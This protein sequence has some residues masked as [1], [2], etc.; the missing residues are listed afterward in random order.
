MN[1]YSNGQTVAGKYRIDEYWYA[2]AVSQ[3]YFATQIL[4]DKP[5]VFKMLNSSLA[6]DAEA[7]E[8]F[9]IQARTLSRINNQHVLNVLDYG[10]DERGLSFLVLENAAGRSLREIIE[11]EGSLSLEQATSIATQVCSALTAA[12]V[13]NTVHGNLSSD[14]ILVSQRNGGDFVQVLDFGA[15]NWTSSDEEKTIVRGDLPFYKAPEQLTNQS[16]P[17]YR[18]DIYAL[19]VILFEML[20]GRRPFTG[21]TPVTIAQKHLDEIPPSLLAARPDLPPVLE[22]IVQRAL[23]KQPNQRFQSAQDLAE[24]LNRA[25]SSADQQRSALSDE[26]FAFANAQP[27]PVR[28]ET[29]DENNRW[30][31]AF[32][33]LAGISLLSL[34]TIF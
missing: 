33:V 19:G 18:S 6:G 22:Q 10:T 26:Q 21:E 15:M 28:A 32:I 30:K 29:I 4:I 2:D 23:A 1:D 25:A 12:Q 7:I 20:S 31:T 27:R 5:V 16:A 14:K 9:Q 24:A 11:N 3:T 8:Y 13:S 34:V 17:D